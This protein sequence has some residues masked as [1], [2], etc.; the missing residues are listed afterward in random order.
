[1]LELQQHDFSIEYCPGSQ[2]R[3]AD[4]LSRN[5]NDSTRD[6]PH[7]DT[8]LTTECLAAENLISNDTK[9]EVFRKV[10]QLVPKS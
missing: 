10:E 8:D 7:E 9:R 5:F 4:A 6:N 1:M 2:N 3:V